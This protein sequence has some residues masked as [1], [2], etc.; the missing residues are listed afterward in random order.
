LAD[1]LDSIVN[2]GNFVNSGILPRLIAARGVG[3]NRAFSFGSALTSGRKGNA[4][5]GF[6]YAAAIQA[7]HSLG[8]LRS[9]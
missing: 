6:C 5:Q 8:V 7:N 3:W 9:A 1:Y 4:S 2:S